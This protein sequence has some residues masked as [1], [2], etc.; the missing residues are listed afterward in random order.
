MTT[1]SLPDVLPVAA[2]AD[3]VAG[4]PQGHWTYACVG[5]QFHPDHTNMIVCLNGLPS[6]SQSTVLSAMRTLCKM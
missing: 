1:V 4:P 3:D 5:Y 2:P 6:H